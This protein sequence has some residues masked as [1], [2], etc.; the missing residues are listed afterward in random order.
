MDVKEKGLGREEPSFGHRG[1]QEELVRYP[2]GNYGWNKFLTTEAQPQ[3]RLH[4]TWLPGS[5]PSSHRSRKLQP[6]DLASLCREI[7]MRVRWKHTTTCYYVRET[8]HDDERKRGFGAI[9]LL[10]DQSFLSVSLARRLSAAYHIR[11]P[12][13]DHCA[14][15]PAPV[16]QSRGYQSGH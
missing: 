15:L 5:R 4:T 11:Q 14:T 13:A 10:M 9:T 8:P 1:R 12:Y 3:F 6:C 7:W 2:Q 16:A